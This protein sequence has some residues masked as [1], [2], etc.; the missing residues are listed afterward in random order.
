MKT[1]SASGIEAI[2]FYEVERNK[3]KAESPARREMPKIQFQAFIS[4]KLLFGM[5]KNIIV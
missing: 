3:D 2:S 4:P 5:K 1:N